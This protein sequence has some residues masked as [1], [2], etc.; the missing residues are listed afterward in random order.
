MGVAGQILLVEGFEEI[1][2]VKVVEFFYSF[3]DI[4]HVLKSLL[5]HG[6]TNIINKCRIIQMQ[7]VNSVAY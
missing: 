6:F 7:K 3:F 4:F 2:I 1:N 5:I